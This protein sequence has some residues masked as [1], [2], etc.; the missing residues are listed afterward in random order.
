MRFETMKLLRGA[1]RSYTEI[2]EFIDSTSRP[3]LC[4]SYDKAL[5]YRE[6]F[7]TTLGGVCRRS[8]RH[9]AETCSRI[10]RSGAG[11]VSQDLA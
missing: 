11:G 6:E 3:V 9:G 5:R 4:V 10:H 7:V 8:Y 1:L 2:V